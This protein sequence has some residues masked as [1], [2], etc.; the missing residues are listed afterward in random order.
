MDDQG[1][2]GL[3]DSKNMAL[4][5]GVIERF[6]VDLRCVALF[7]FVELFFVLF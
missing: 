5:N 6:P 7:L 4:L 3:Q 2:G 1:S